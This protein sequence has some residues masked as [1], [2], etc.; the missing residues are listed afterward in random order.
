MVSLRSLEC[1]VTIVEQGSLTKAAK[2]LHL[3]QPALSHQIAG[4]SKITA[5]QTAPLSSCDGP[6]CAIAVG[7]DANGIDLIL[8]VVG[9]GLLLP[10]LIFIGAS[11]RL[12]A[13]RR[14]QRFAAMRLTGATPRQITVIASVESAVAAAAGTDG[15][16]RAV[17]RAA[18][19]D[20]L[21]PVQRGSVLHQR[22]V[23]EHP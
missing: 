18:A 20:R 12:S 23:A 14:E 11:T 13:A 5:I 4:A 9:I 3:S 10:V 1:L 15:R 17:L 19:G 8:S 7:I 21:V 16:L 2:V 6:S 22:P